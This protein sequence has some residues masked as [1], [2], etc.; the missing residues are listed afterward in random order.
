MNKPEYS[1]QLLLPFAIEYN[2]FSGSGN[3]DM[4]IVK[5]PLLD[6]PYILIT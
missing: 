4:D 5:G 2:I 3:L 6:L 1:Y